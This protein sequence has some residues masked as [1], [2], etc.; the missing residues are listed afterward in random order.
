MIHIDTY[1]DRHLPNTAD[2]FVIDDAMRRRA[3]RGLF[4][5]EKASLLDS[6]AW[7]KTEK[8]LEE[9]VEILSRS[10]AINTAYTVTDLY[11]VMANIHIQAT[12][13]YDQITAAAVNQGT[14]EVLDDEMYR[15]K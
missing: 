12:Q 7:Q 2:C 14:I 8:D 3:L 4:E 15:L 11:R 1:P 9:Y 5:R 6:D 10:M 13:K